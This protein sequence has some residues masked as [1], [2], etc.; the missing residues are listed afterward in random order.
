[1]IFHVPIFI[2]F[3]FLYN[4]IIALQTIT[5]FARYK[6]KELAYAGIFVSA[7][8]MVYSFG[9]AMELIFITSSDISSAFL[10]YKIQYFAIA[11]I[12]FSFFVFVNAFVGKKVKK[13]IIILLMIIPLVTI[14]LLWTNQFHHLYLKGYLEGGKYVIPAP[15]FYIKLIYEYVLIGFSYYIMLSEIRKKRFLFSRKTIIHLIFAVMI[16]L[17]LNIVY[18]IFRM[19]I[20]LTAFGL[21]ASII[22]LFY[23]SQ[24]KYGLDFREVA[25]EITFDFTND[26]IVVI[27]KEEHILSHNKSF[28][29]MIKEF[30]GIEELAYKNISEILSQECISAIRNG[31][32]IVEKFGRYFQISVVDIKE[33]VK[34]SK[35]EGKA[36]F[37]HEI[38][39]IKKLEEEVIAES[40]KYQALFEFSPLGILVEDSNGNIL[41]VNPEFCKINGLRKEELIG[42]HVSI[43]APKEDYE[44]VIKNIKEII[45][46]KTLIH[47]V[48]NLSR[49]GEVK[50]LELYERKITLPDGKDGILSI[51][52]D[53]TK[54][55]M[56]QKVIKS[57]AKYQQIILQLALNIINTPVEKIDK[58]IK[59][60]IELIAKEL[61]TSRIRVYKFSADG[62]FNSISNWFYS[63]NPI[64]NTF[65]SF[66][67]KDVS[68]KELDELM[69]G[70]QFSIAKQN[71]SN[72]FIKKMF[73]ENSISLITPIKINENVIGFI[74]AAFKEDRALT[75]AEK[76]IFLLLA[77]LLANSEIRKKY[78][79]E[80]IK[81]KQEAEKANQAKSIFLANMSHEIRTPLNGIIGFTNLLKETKL[82]EKQEKYVS[83]ILKSS[84]LLLEIINDILDLA[85]IESGKYQLEPLETNLKMELQSSLLLY[86]AKAKE[87]NV[88]YEIRIDK[89]ISNCLIVDSVRLQQVMFNLINNA[90]KFTP[91]G[92]SVKV[93]VK[94]ISE[95]EEHE[96]IRFSVIDTGIGIPKEKLE[97]IFEPFEQ[98]S[99]SV[100]KKYGGTGL[101]FAIS[102]LIVSMM[103]SKI[104]VES[105]EEKGSHFYFDLKLKKCSKKEITQDMKTIK[106]K[107]YNAKVLVAEDYEINRILIEEI[108]NKY[109]IKP[110]FA[111]NGKEAVEMALNKDYDIIFMDVLMPEMDGIE[112]TKKIKA[113][114]PNLPIIALTAH[115]LKSVKEEVL[116]VGMNDYITKPIKIADLERVLNKFC[117]HLESSEKSE[118]EA[119]IFNANI[120]GEKREINEIE[121]DI[122]I[123]KQEQGFDEEFMKELIK[124]FINSTKES[125][126][127]IRNALPK[128]DFKT[129]QR[130]AHSIKGAARSLNFNSIG[131]LAYQLEIKAK[132]KDDSFDYETHLTQI[133]EKLRNVIN[134]FR[135]KYEKNN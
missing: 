53:I 86:E 58:E 106:S 66:N 118:K 8:I 25:K 101:G 84:E 133:E 13:S 94:K 35:F 76:R 56:A 65:V 47:T 45:S 104:I 82:D 103:G 107:K 52:K 93:F 92:G 113:I 48:R 119:R 87:K 46:G 71:V 78:E 4:S 38:T 115:A 88:E 30:F 79:E 77:T 57:L 33:K 41:D 39:D 120:V 12:S 62:S 23:E 64:E 124:M 109:D 7:V 83:I 123:T 21:M 42:Q 122:E 121:K 22:I 60:A 108:L 134:F 32:G 72:E 117:S 125:I 18:T 128:V 97:K 44:Q 132:E 116:S 9:Y 15:W 81:A 100:T 67:I 34:N 27:D 36:V 49:S 85:K 111:V 37:F 80:L 59:R 90:I 40:K 99:V 20:D 74:S 17:S 19:N 2:I 14:I 91:A 28:S 3:L 50:Y 135:I 5:I 16:P 131:E 6:V 63:N 105:E 70:K 114:K 68:G 96:N 130:E 126:L 73:G 26:M 129:I 24:K 69:A 43:L 1:M 75:V 54:I 110:D 95:D 112:A 10:W 89:E 51:Q 127:N 55:V 31:Y 11:F 29:S 102:N 98:A 61:N